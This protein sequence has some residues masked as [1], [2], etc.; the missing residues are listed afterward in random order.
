MLYFVFAFLPSETTE[1][2]K[3]YIVAGFRVRELCKSPFSQYNLTVLKWWLESK[4]GL[5]SALAM[6]IFCLLIVVLTQVW[7]VF[8]G[9]VNMTAYLAVPSIPALC[10]CLLADYRAVRRSQGD[11]SV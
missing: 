3:A 11:D 6:T 2:I 10:C 8:C 5:W 4:N 9:L 7:R 1:V